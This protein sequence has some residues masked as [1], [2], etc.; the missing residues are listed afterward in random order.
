M[1]PW[2]TRI[3]DRNERVLKKLKPLVDRINEFEPALSRLTDQE[4]RRKTD[5]FRNRLADGETLDELLPEAFA[6]IR[7]AAK[8]TIGQR[9]FDVQLMGGI[10]LHQGKIIEMRTGEGKTLVATLPVYLN[11]LTGKGVHIITVNDYLAERDSHGR[12]NFKGM[13]NIYESL[14]LSVGCILHGLRMEERQAAYAADIAYG[15]NNEFGFDYLRDNMAVAKEYMV[16]RKLNYCIVD[17]V[18]SILVDEARTPLIISGPAEE[19]TDKYYTINRIIPK[20]SAE[21]DYK[22]DEKHKNVTLTEDGVSTVEKLLHLENL[23]DEQN[24]EVLH[25]VVQGLRA[26]TLFKRE[27]DYIVKDSKVV[28]VDEFTG[29]LMPGRRW[30]DGLH[31]AIEAK[32][33]AEIEEENQTLATITFQNYFRMYEKLAGMTGTA[34]TEAQEF[35]EIYKLDAIVIP[36]HKPMVRED[37]ADQ[38]YRTEREKHK[39]IIEDIAEHYE[40]GQPMLV[41]TTSIERNEK[42]SSMLKRRGVPHQVLNAKQHEQ[43]AHI[44]AQAGQAK[45]ITIATNMAGRGT[46][47]QLGPGVVELGGLYVLGTERNESRRIDNQL[48][49]RSG[50]QGD[51]GASR[52]Y[53][54]LEDDLL[55]L[56]AVENLQN[57]MSKL[58]MQEDEVIEHPWV[59]KAI[60]RAQ[61]AVETRNFELRK[62]LLEY[63]DVMNKQ[64][65]VI[66]AQRRAIL[67]GED[68]SGLILDM[69]DELVDEAVSTY[70]PK[71]TP[72][73][74]GAIQTLVDWLRAVFNLHVPPSDL[75]REQPDAVAA[76][77]TQRLRNIYRE[78]ETGFGPD[79]M[80]EMERI[81]MLNII[82]AQWKNHLYNMDQLKE[83]IG[84]AAYGQKDPLIEYKR[85]GFAMFQAML[86]SIKQKTLEVLF[87]I[88]AALPHEEARRPFAYEGHEER[89]PIAALPPQPSPP[90]SA[91]GQAGALSPAAATFGPLPPG[92][93]PEFGQSPDELQQA[94]GGEEVKDTPYRREIPKVGRNDPCP[95]GSGKKYKKCHG[96]A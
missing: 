29:R 45:T 6:V 7:E 54:S 82:D 38:I 1:F 60:E 90:S 21:A 43:E 83:G 94:G 19:S 11:A 8:R 31:Q 37:Q 50:R 72:P 33:G 75:E 15:T 65:E 63:D 68:I 18:D 16:Q 88:K 27:T 56:F 47:I 58:G 53:L 89:P 57:W 42:L 62:H 20:L 5:E 84:L 96:A 46:D 70:L 23:Y 51:P 48:R 81:V 32:E 67:E 95:C 69:V 4:L 93:P 66:Y 24:I 44:I 79:Q 35:M 39:A 64:R 87:H 40:R 10:I 61:K 77:L 22:I 71:N 14:G 12:G 80:R 52:Y 91:R 3:L 76:H 30:S 49:G 25:H 86:S 34:R 59:T 85:E 92:A 9:P 28:I 2:L 17:E 78:R 55:R 36:T 73:A 41:G 13:G 74:E 26:H